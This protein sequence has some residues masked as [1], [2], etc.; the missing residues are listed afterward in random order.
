L[1]QF[2]DRPLRVFVV[3]EKALPT[4][5]VP[6]WTAVLSRVRDRRV[7]Q[8][9]DKEDVLSQNLRAAAFGGPAVRKNGFQMGTLIWDFVAVFPP[10]APWDGS[11]ASAQFTGAPAF[12]VA[13]DVRQYLEAH[14][15]VAA[16]DRR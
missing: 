2:P 14:G 11:L 13:A 7:S 12:A 9:W 3:W 15:A 4:D 6:P 16:A 5:W 10:R 1:E 8:Y